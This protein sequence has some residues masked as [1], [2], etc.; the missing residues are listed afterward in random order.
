MNALFIGIG[1]SARCWYRCALPARALGADWI[2][3]GGHPTALVIRTGQCT[4]DIGG[5][6]DLATYDTVVLQQPH[7]PAWSNAIAELRRRGTRVLFEV[8]EDPRGAA[9]ATDRGERTGGASPATVHA[10]EQAMSACDGIICPTRPLADALRGFN[11]DAWV[12]PNGIDLGRY[13][14][15]RTARETVTIG[16][17]GR[18]AASGAAIAPWRR[19]LEEVLASRP[20]TSFMSVGAEGVASALAERFGPRRCQGLPWGP[21]ET[22]P[23]AMSSFDIALAPAAPTTCFRSRGDLQWLE[24]AALAIPV[25]AGAALHPE[26]ED[27]VTG[28]LAATPAQ[29]R[30]AILAL[31]DDEGL[32]DRIGLAARAYVR[33]HRCIEAV[34][35]AWARALA[36][37]SAAAQAA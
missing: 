24:A 20:A 29:A 4:R 23:A 7:G 36:G 37:A 1:T 30:A 9:N 18:A 32:R 22:Y 15:S 5:I 28:L 16:W 26:I 33:E 27:G 12:C 31:V 25:V 19:E 6:D 8:D 2:G 35:P 11:E 34:A 13:A 14:L 21:I 3:V 17:A 10:L